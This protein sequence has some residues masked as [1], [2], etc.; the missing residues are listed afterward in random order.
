MAGASQGQSE[1]AAYALGHTDQELRRLA[2]QARL[3]DPITRH[4]LIMA[5]ITQGMRVLD[6]GSGAG[7][8]AILAAALVGST[9]EVVGSDPATSAVDTARERSAGQV[10]AECIVPGGRSSG[11]GV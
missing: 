10:V 5:G 1:P 11:D 8:V 6:I 2:T 7:D 9:G 3:N 4:F